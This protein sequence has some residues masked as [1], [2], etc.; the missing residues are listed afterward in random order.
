MDG[1]IARL[2]CTATVVAGEG[3]ERQS[4]ALAEGLLKTELPA[5]L[6]AALERVLADDPTVYVA[7]SLHCEVHTGPAAS[8]VTL[9]RSIA[10]QLAR[11]VRDPD[12]DGADLV[13]FASV[14]DYLAAFLAALAKGD[15]W[16]H[17]YF[18]PLRRLARLDPP[19]VFLALDAEGHDMARVVQ[20]LKRSG[21]LGQ[22]L[23]A[24]GEE[25][26]AQ[27]WPS[28]RRAPPD[29]AEWLSLVRL[30][31]DLARALG[32]DISGHRD[33]EAWAAELA[34][35]AG[36]ELDWTDPVVLAHALAR[37]VRLVSGPAADGRHVSAVQLP[38]GLD[39][40]D[41]DALVQA[42]SA[43]P[44]PALTPG[45]QAEAPVPVPRPP[46][47]RAI[48]AALSRLISGGA[49]VLDRRSPG[50]AAIMAWAALTEQMP[51]LAGA[52]WARDAVRGF[53]D[54]RLAGAGPAAVRDE[55]AGRAGADRH[56]MA[57][58]VPCA[59]IYLLLRTLDAIKMPALCRRA[60][61][62]AIA[63]LE[64]LA[65]RWAGPVDAAAALRPITG[66]VASRAGSLS[67]DALQL[68]QAEVARVAV[69]QRPV[70]REVLRSRAVP[71]GAT[72]MAVILG[73]AD[74]L[75][76]L[77]GQR[78]DPARP[79]DPA[80]PWWQEV[81]GGPAPRTESLAG[82][83]DDP[84]R[85]LLLADLA[86]MAHAHAGDPE[87]DLP[88]DLIALAVLRHWAWWLRGFSTAS[89]PCLL[90]TF[91]RR[92]GRL[93][94]DDG[95]VHVGLSRRPHDVVLD[96][97]GCLDSVELQWPWGPGRVRRVEFTMG[98]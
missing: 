63:L 53:V 61:V 66:E 39:W 42:L 84:G 37:A 30:A 28:S 48:E 62:P 46:R 27:M 94:T 76:W 35:G 50:T 82:D 73:D 3:D 45:G 5:A 22:V 67:A 21:D 44:P 32:W 59:G 87:I 88:L 58:E 6:P 64:A 49:V 17:W 65:R 13:R 52:A 72:A 41:T 18:G 55:T 93:T 47:T 9:A 90:A 89:I 23:S 79:A 85:A 96:V 12:R 8:G 91:I 69:T 36:A 33:L 57:T 98:A 70:T 7:R 83:A 86:T 1:R 26:L 92:P 60:G 68:L 15:A 16:R 56:C 51:E 11:A 24:V 25:A 20:A 38:A 95:T 54:R 77:G 4:A 2:V 74:D 40:V 34:G 71:F 10:A 31:L 14:A 97:S 19:A 75:M 81:T 78:Q 29:Q 80:L 43:P